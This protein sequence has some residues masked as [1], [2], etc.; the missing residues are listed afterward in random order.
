MSNKGE[1]AYVTKADGS[2]IRIHVV[3]SL[4]EKP[5]KSLGFTFDSSLGEYTRTVK[6]I[7]E[8]AQ[9]FDELR[10]LDVSFSGG[11]EWCPAEVFEFLRDQNI[12]SGSFK[13]IVWTD[14][15]T[16]KVTDA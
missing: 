1:A 5:L 14:R 9:A 3:D 6:S 11:R 2:E 16:T 15:V 13:K 4:I 10:N 7:S 12:L 8:K